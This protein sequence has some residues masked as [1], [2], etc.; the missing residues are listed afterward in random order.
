VGSFRSVG[1]SGQQRS[2]GSV[3]RW[4]VGSNFIGG[5]TVQLKLQG[6]VSLIGTI[7]AAV[8]WAS[9]NVKWSNVGNYCL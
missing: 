9:R 8:A 2:G 7:N 6:S 1:E 5:G 4:W 3:Y